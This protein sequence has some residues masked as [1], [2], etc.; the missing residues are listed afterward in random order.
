MV[1]RQETGGGREENRERER[2]KR[3]EMVL[4]AG[5]V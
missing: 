5:E 2:G 1:R 4:F 3:N